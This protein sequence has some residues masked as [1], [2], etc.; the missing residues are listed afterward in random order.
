MLP[1]HRYASTPSAA[2]LRATKPCS[3]C[4]ACN[5]YSI[6]ARGA[7][8]GGLRIGSVKI[9]RQGGGPGRCRSRAL[10]LPHARSDFVCLG[11]RAVCAGGLLSLSLRIAIKLACI[12]CKDKTLYSSKATLIFCQYVSQKTA[13]L[14]KPKSR[15]IK[16]RTC[17]DQ[18]CDPENRAHAEGHVQRQRQQIR[19]DLT[20]HKTRIV[21]IKIHRRFLHTDSSPELIK[22]GTCN[23]HTVATQKIEH[24]PRAT[25]NASA[26]KYGTT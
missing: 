2:R 17:N 13:K 20:F 12:Y 11:M 8:V 22:P 23:D 25:F 24:T 10:R 14:Y 4:L 3:K 18:C 19:H 16:A 15:A 6:T 21:N 9:M 7:G 26:S 1:K 5:R